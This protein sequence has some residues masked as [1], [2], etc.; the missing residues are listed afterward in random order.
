MPDMDGFDVAD[1]LA[2]IGC[3][4]PIAFMTG[5]VP[6]L[7]KDGHLFEAPNIIR[8]P[9]SIKDIATFARRV[10]EPEKAA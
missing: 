2:E 4:A 9:F 8:K 6:D 7:E 10:L 5:C 3:R 1:L